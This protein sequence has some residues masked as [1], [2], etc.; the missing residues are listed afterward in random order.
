MTIKKKICN[1]F[2]LLL[3][4]LIHL[5]SNNKLLATTGV[6]PWIKLAA[7]TQSK[8]STCFKTSRTRTKQRICPHQAT[9][10]PIPSCPK[11]IP[12]QKTECPPVTISAMPRSAVRSALIIFN[13][14][15]S[16]IWLIW[17]TLSRL[18]SAFP[19]SS[20]LLKLVQ[21]RIRCSLSTIK[22]Q[23]SRWLAPSL[24]SFLN[25]KTER[26]MIVFLS[27]LSKLTFSVVW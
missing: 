4:W 23:F 24:T 1:L 20:N 7:V 27:G 2:L 6:S 13:S 15:K 10:K 12:T 25:L 11:L 21:M 9:D 3:N 14:S 5:N 16:A 17:F 18:L 26:C 22:K 19:F 8:W